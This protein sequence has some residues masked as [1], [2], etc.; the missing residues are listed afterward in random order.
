MPMARRRALPGIAPRPGQPPNFLDDG[1][2]YI[3]HVW[4]R[5]FSRRQGGLNGVSSG[6]RPL[7]FA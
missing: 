4:P 3:L 6:V 5:A 1:Q 7:L 2:Y